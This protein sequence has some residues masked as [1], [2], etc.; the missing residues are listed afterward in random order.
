VAEQH[1]TGRHRPD[2]LDPHLLAAPLRLDRRGYAGNLDHN[3]RHRFVG[4]GDAAVGV[5]AHAPALALI[6]LSSC[7]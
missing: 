6:S 5:E 7:S 2:E 1:V 4:A 3:S